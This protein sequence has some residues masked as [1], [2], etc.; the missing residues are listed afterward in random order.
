MDEKSYKT[1]DCGEKM[2]YNK[3]EYRIQRKNGRRN[4]ILKERKHS[5]R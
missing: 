1:I 3:V 5:S 4:L 2:C